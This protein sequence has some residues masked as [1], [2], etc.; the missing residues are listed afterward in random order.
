MFALAVVAYVNTIPN[1]LVFDDLLLITEQSSVR[2]A[3]NW[4]EIWF[5]RYWGEIWPHNVLYR[6]LTIWS[7]ALN[8]SFNGLLGLSCSHTA[9][10]H[11]VNLL[12]HAA[13]STLVLRLGIALCIPSFASFAAALI[14]AV[15][16]IHTE[17]VAAVT[18]RTELLA[19]GF[20][21]GFILAHDHRHTAL[22]AV[23][24]ALAL[25][26]KES[27]IAF[28]P[29]ALLCVFS[30]D[31][32]RRDIMA[33][34]LYGLVTV[35]WFALRASV[36]SGIVIPLDTLPLAES[37]TYVRILT[38]LRVQVR[39]LG[40]QVAPVGLSSDYSMNQIPT[41]T[42]LLDPHI[43][44][45]LCLGAGAA[46]II[47]KTWRVSAIPTILIL[48]YTITFLPTSNI[49]LPIG[50]IMGE[51][52][53]YTPS[54]FVCLGLG[55]AFDALRKMVSGYAVALLA[56]LLVVFVWGTVDR[57]ATWADPYTFSITQLKTA[58]NS[59]KANYN[60]GR[61]H[62]IAGDV[63][64]A[65]E[66]YR[67]AL[68]IK[69]A[70]ADALNNLGV[71][72]RWQG[73]LYEAVGY[74]KN[75]IY[76]AP[77]LASAHYNLGQTLRDMGDE[78]GAMTSYRKALE[79]HPEYA[80][81]ANN[82]ALIFVRQGDLDRARKLWERALQIRPDYTMARENLKRLDTVGN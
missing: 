71:A 51:R 81:A 54:I 52:L 60:A 55:Y 32:A 57:N 15:H 26:S 46:A 78:S 19:A 7:I 70:Y 41:V 17:A 35:A 22:A 12:L 64:K 23:L 48:G 50:T 68:E 75:A 8:Y 29:V 47:V 80:E 63:A 62:H 58:P 76:L 69:P 66:H 25:F 6:P 61:E 16:P 65:V 44:V 73:A 3:F 82:L 20:G 37:P 67:R 14:F 42:T 9:G 1:G 53:A 24:F 27:A 40:L 5:G 13:V 11:V 38:A 43:V 77:G 74:F 28:L 34:G 4:R 10:Y 59:A 72:K 36:V 2:S 31:R 39:Y 33:F 21:I 18:G 49:L 30:K 45:A 56:A 79:I